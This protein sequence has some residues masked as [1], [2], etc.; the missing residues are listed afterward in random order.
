MAEFTITYESEY[1]DLAAAGLNVPQKKKANSKFGSLDL[2][3]LEKDGYN[4]LGWYLKGTST[5]VNINDSISKDMTLVA[6]WQ[7][8]KSGP[9]ENSG[10]GSGTGSASSEIIED[11]TTEVTAEGIKLT[12]IVPAYTDELS[13]RRKKVNVTQ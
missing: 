2:P 11:T 8:I 7:K 9:G 10:S 4:F 13:I 12:I 1:G 3:A 6:R 5:K